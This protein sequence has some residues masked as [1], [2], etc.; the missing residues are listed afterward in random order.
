MREFMQTISSVETAAV[1][2]ARTLLYEG[3]LVQLNGEFVGAV[4]AIPK[5]SEVEETQSDLHDNE[6]FIRDNVPVAIYLLLDGKHQIVRHFLNTCLQLQSTQFQT[7]GIFPTSFVEVQGNLVADYGQRAI[8]RVCSVDATLWWAILAYIYV[9]RTGD[10]EWATSPGVQVGLQ[11]FL[12]L[13]LHPQFRDAPTLYVPD[14]AFM[15]DRPLDV[16]GNPLEIQ[17]LLYGALLSAAALIQMDLQ[18]KRNSTAVP[19]AFTEEQQRQFEYAIAWAKRLRSYLLKHYWVTSQTVQLLR[20]RPTEQYGEAARNEYNIQTETIPHWLQDWL[21]ARGGYLIG[22]IRTGRPDFRFFTL[23]NCLGA[24][25]D[26]LSAPQQRTL[27]HLFSRNRNDLFAQMPLHI[28]HPPLSSENWRGLTGYDR[29]NLPWCYHN[30]GHWPCL[31]WFLAATVLRHQ[32][33]YGRLHLGLSTIEA[34]IGDS[35]TRLLACLPQQRWAEY[36]DGPTG[37]WIGQQARL[38]Q[39]WTIASFLIVH[40]LLRVNPQDARILD[41]PT[42]RMLDPNLKD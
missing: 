14:G 21:G 39:T 8:G 16:W 22:N 2:Q 31:L 29:K 6:I 25:F 11:R 28:C 15:I 30:G 24:A 4:A 35:Y 19:D 23:G 37:I 32:E 26:I 20:R 38:Y 7:K 40:H 42:F 36:F 12:N 27:F 9:K 34:L 10:R 17:V 33:H 18:D 41:I 1:K 5:R 3:A 13:I